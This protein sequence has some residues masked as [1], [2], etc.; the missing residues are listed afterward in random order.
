METKR[1]MLYVLLIVC[2]SPV[3]LACSKSKK[4][5]KKVDEVET[6]LSSGYWHM[7]RFIKNHTNQMSHFSGFAFTFHD[8]GKVTATNN[9]VTHQGT[10]SVTTESD[11]DSSAD[12]QLNIHF[13]TEDYFQE[14]SKDWDIISHESILI[15]LK[16]V[17]GGNGSTDYLTFKKY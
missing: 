6:Y 13:D 3:F 8:D 12:M 9:S 1:I 10:W 11:D 4:L 16:H 14:M 17:S 15:D 7:S 2:L 5:D